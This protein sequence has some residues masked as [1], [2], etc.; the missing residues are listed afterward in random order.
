[1]RNRLAHIAL[2]AIVLISP[3]AALAGKKTITDETNSTFFAS[4]WIGSR[5]IATYEHWIFYTPT[6][7]PGFTSTST[8]IYYEPLAMITKLPDNNFTP[9][10]PKEVNAAFLS[11]AHYQV[12]AYLAPPDTYFFFTGAV[13]VMQS[14]PYGIPVQM[15]VV[16]VDSTITCTISLGDGN[17]PTAPIALPTKA[18]LYS[19]AID[20]GDAPGACLSGK[21]IHGSPK[22]EQVIS[23]VRIR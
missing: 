15:G 23:E 8:G 17:V 4:A 12:G 10:G 20:I 7:Q 11:G 21:W 6:L 18:G 16:G 5:L 13:D 2:A 9:A 19:V 3:L 1:M 22:D 14:L